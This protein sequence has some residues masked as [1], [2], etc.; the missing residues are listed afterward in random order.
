[1]QD[2]H[3]KQQASKDIVPICHTEHDFNKGGNF[4]PLHYYV[5]YMEHSFLISPYLESLDIIHDVSEI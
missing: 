1:M 3:I 5:L 4:I 2:K